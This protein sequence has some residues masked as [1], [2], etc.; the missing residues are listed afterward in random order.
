L[1]SFEFGKSV[2]GSGTDCA[3]GLSDIEMLGRNSRRFS[4]VRRS[5]QD[6]ECFRGWNH[7]GLPGGDGAWSLLVGEVS[8]KIISAVEAPRDYLSC[9][10]GRV[11][12]T[13]HVRGPVIGSRAAVHGT[14]KH[15]R[16]LTCF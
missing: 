16:V 15:T 1:C 13:G 11:A 10:A 3:A 9:H 14:R 2:V 4:A 7:E 5:Q 8:P 12:G 6:R